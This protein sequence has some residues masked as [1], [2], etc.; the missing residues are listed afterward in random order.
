MLTRLGPIAVLAACSFDHGV[1]PA[2]AAPDAAPTT[3]TLFV[4]DF[5]AG[6]V[7][8]YTITRGE[9]TPPPP[10][11]FA[12]TS[13]LVPIIWPPTGELLVDEVTGGMIAR[14]AAPFAT[15]T[16]NGTISGVGLSMTAKM[17]VVDSELWVVDP[18]SANV[19][20]L[21]FDSTGRAT[22]AGMFGALNGRGIVF[23]PMTRSVFITE[24]CGTDTILHF[25]VDASHNL[26]MLPPT[27]G[28]G[29]SS[30]HGMLITPWRELFVADLGAA[31]ILR[32]VFDAAG[33]PVANGVI[34][35]NGLNLPVDLLMSPWNELYVINQGAGA[36]SR[37][38][39][40]ASHAAT[41]HGTFAVPGANTIAWGFIPD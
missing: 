14:F 34:T 2:D 38:T 11:S 12:V 1:V 39:F 17:A 30:P 37:F 8:R 7:H 29:L 10:L 13:G 6:M 33:N 24:C 35:G 21:A 18:G 4:A 31:S 5:G 16:P 23:D 32:F 3:S 20:R 41:A 19:D 40:D 26:G 27:T 15:P 25:S 22:M 36:V 9:A 28:N